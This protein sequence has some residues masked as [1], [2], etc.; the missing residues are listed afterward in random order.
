MLLEPWL[1][2]L[3]VLGA[4]T[5]VGGGVML[6][7]IG[8]R[9]RQSEN[10]GLIREF[11]KT[12]SYAGLRILAPAMVTVLISGALL[13]LTSPG[14]KF[15]QLWILLALGAFLVAFLIGAVYLSRI[16]MELQRLAAARI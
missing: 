4:I 6:S 8:M 10:A 13:V 1:H 12:L 3:H 16:A 7:V 11:V 9:V 14:W 2:F 5:W 15:T